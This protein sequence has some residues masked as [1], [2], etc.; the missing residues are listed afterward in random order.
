MRYIY[1]GDR[2]TDPK[3]INQ[4]CDPVLNSQ[5]KCICGRGNMLVVFAN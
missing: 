4:P 5:G 1:F 3:W 2:L